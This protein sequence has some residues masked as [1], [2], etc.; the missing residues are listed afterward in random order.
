M[1]RSPTNVLFGAFG[2]GTA[3]GKSAADLTVPVTVEDAAMQIF[4]PSY[5]GGSGHGSR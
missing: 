4:M 1:N 5:G 2:G 3:S